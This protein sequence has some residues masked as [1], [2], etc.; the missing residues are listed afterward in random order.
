MILIRRNPDGAYDSSRNLPK[1][2]TA[3]KK[4]IEVEVREMPEA[5]SVEALEGTLEGKPGDF[6]ITGVQGE[7]YPCDREI[8]FATYELLSEAVPASATP[9]GN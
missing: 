1:S 2:M 5:F 4:P 6:L 3:V 8:F 7:M 9:G